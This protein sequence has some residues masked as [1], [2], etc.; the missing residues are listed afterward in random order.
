MRRWNRS[1]SLMPNG[2]SGYLA[3][4]RG[5]CLFTLACT[6]NAQCGFRQGRKALFGNRLAAHLAAAVGAVVYSAQ[7]GIDGLDFGVHHRDFA[8]ARIGVLDFRGLFLQIGI[9]RFER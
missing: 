8:L 7:S 4:S 9:E 1:I 2:P 6:S 3:I 5:I